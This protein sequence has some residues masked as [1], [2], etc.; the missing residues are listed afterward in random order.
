MAAISNSAAA[1]K[2]TAAQNPFFLTV[3]HRFANIFASLLQND[4]LLIVPVAISFSSLFSD[5]DLQSII[6]EEFVGTVSGEKGLNTNWITTATHVLRASSS[7]SDKEYVSLN[8]KNVTIER[9]V[10]VTGKELCYDDS[11]GKV[12]TLYCIDQPLLPISDIL[13]GRHVAESAVS[14]QKILDAFGDVGGNTLNRLNDVMTAFN[15]KA[16]MLEDIEKLHEEMKGLLDSAFQIVSTLPPAPL[17]TILSTHALTRDE[18]HQV[19]ETFILENTYEMVYFRISKEFRDRDARVADV[20]AKVQS[21]DLGQMG[22]LEGEDGKEGE[23]RGREL[24]RNLGVAVKEFQRISAVRTPFEKIKCL[25]RSVYLLTSSSN[26]TPS[27]SQRKAPAGRPSLHPPSPTHLSATSSPSNAAPG[28]LLT[29]DQL[30]PLLV[31]LVIRSNV[32]NLHSSL[33]YMQNFT[34]EHDVERGEFGYAISS[35]EAV[36]GYII[37]HED[38]L[39]LSCEKNEGWWRRVCEST[40]DGSGGVKEALY[41]AVGENGVKG[42]GKENWVVSRNW[43][44]DDALLMATRNSKVEIVEYLLKSGFSAN[45]QNYEGCS[46]LHLTAILSSIPIAEL[47]ISHSADVNL[48]DRK[49]NTPLIVASSHSNLA[50]VDFLLSRSA[51][52]NS[53]NASGLTAL[54]VTTSLPILETLLKHGADV[55]AMSHEGLTPL[56]YHCQLGRMEIVKGL[57]EYG[58]DL[59]VRD[60]GGR[61]CLHLCA[62]RG[63]TD[64]VRL[65]LAREGLLSGSRDSVLVAK[66]SGL[67]V[68]AV[69]LRGNT[70]LH[71]AA[72]P[73]H[74]EIVQMLLDAGSDVTKRNISGLVAADL[75]K[76]EGVR[77]L[78]DDYGLLSSIGGKSS[79]SG[80]HPPLMPSRPLAQV[81]D[82]DRPLSELRVE[83]ERIA[84]V[85][86]HVYVDGEVFF[87]VKSGTPGDQGSVVTVRRSLKDF[88]FLRKQLTTES[89]EACL[90]DIKELLTSQIFSGGNVAPSIVSRTLRKIVKRLNHFIHYLLSH[91]QFSTHELVWEFLVVPELDASITNI[92]VRTR[93]KLESLHDTIMDTYPPLVDSLD[94]EDILFKQAELTLTSLQ[95]AI[96][97]VG[98]TARRVGKCRR[99]LSGCW[100]VVRYHVGR[101]SRFAVLGRDLP[102][103]GQVSETLRKVGEV[104]ARQSGFD[105][106]DIGDA[107]VESLHGISGALSCIPRHAIAAADYTRTAKDTSALSASVVRLEAAAKAQGTEERVKKLSEVYFQYSEAS[108]SMQQKASMLN[109]VDS[110]LKGELSQFHLY[111]AKEVQKSLS[112][113]VLHQLEAEQEALD[114]LTASYDLLMTASRQNLERHHAELRKE[115]ARV[116]KWWRTER[117]PEVVDKKDESTVVMEGMGGE[118]VTL[119]SARSSSSSLASNDSVEVLAREDGREVSVRESV[120]EKVLLAPSGGE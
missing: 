77:D 8:N 93:S 34:F 26:P 81:D 10:V 27:S 86:R 46:P 89:Q 100:R 30:I 99:D 63:Y 108:K 115:N 98:T 97:Q 31:L 50:I 85:V 74:R 90:P 68:S 25:M 78:L 58:A 52:V 62:F 40:V 113:Y 69:S 1:N 104:I 39:I 101:P 37:E 91:P 118:G 109:Y 64:L 71:A 70:P 12:F 56:L 75:A 66:R 35:L 103:L 24:G 59:R 20:I 42:V 112:D 15:D 54:H 83:E 96:K 29:S 80:G 60:L 49:G 7:L 28:P 116:V 3:Q 87:I 11:T 21:L 119:T 44:G 38:G 111:R 41:A 88:A 43:D 9:E 22:V 16:I 57:I 53:R 84:G 73:G 17:Q 47:L 33:H 45:T 114:A 32:Q 82:D 13:E 61:T 102:G 120:V 76:E 65:I 110:N 36:V 14:M 48:P 19:V 105:I 95:S 94:L 4:W 72:E 117:I 107:F 2:N 6:T 106:W 5:K 67:D 79:S 51:S 23:Y 92:T 18:F 55:E